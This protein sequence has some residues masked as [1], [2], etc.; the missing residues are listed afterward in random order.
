MKR[1]IIKE[2]PVG[3]VFNW[4]NRKYQIIEDGETE[5]TCNNCIFKVACYNAFVKTCYN[6]NRLSNP[7]QEMHCSRK[8][9]N[10]RKNIHYEKVRE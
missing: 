9:R 4:R 1:S 5:A 8:T 6:T 3:I 10:D 2:R 7:L